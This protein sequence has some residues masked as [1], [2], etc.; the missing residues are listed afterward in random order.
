VADLG[1]LEG[2][3]GSGVQVQVDYCN[4]VCCYIMPGKGG[5]STLTLVM[6]NMVETWWNMVVYAEALE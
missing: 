6:Q 1:F 3:L 5:R 2:I 4:S